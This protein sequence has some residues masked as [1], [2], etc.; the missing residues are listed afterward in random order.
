MNKKEATPRTCHDVL[1]GDGLGQVDNFTKVINPGTGLDYKGQPMPIYCQIEFTDGKLSITGVEGPKSN[2]DCAGSCGQIVDHLAADIRELS[3]G[4]TPEMLN[5]FV[6]TWNAWHLNDLRAGCE[7]QRA[8]NW[9]REEVEV[10]TYGYA[11]ETRKQRER[12]E[13]EALERLRACGT[14]TITEEER[15]IISLPREKKGPIHPGPYY[16]ERNRETK[17][18]SFLYP[19]EHPAGVLTK[20]CPV[21]GYKYGSQWLKEDVPQDALNWLKSLPD[22]GTMPAWV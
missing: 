8:E 11:T 17:L 18:T 1:P 12:I 14:A 4:W 20:P 13:R 10:I 16:K 7:H 21:C 15:E 5:Q 2:G 22:T 6:E 9:G 3:P 19:D